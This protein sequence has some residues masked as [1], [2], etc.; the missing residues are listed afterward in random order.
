MIDTRIPWNANGAREQAKARGKKLATAYVAKIP[1]R[2]AA[3]AVK[4]K[5][6]RKIG[7]R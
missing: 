6:W 5:A 3:A 7:P 1:K 2:R 4:H